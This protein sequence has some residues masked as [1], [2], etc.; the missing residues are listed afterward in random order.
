MITLLHFYILI[1]QHYNMHILP[2][3]NIWERKTEEIDNS[4]IQQ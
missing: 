2:Y 4:Q 3:N 1:F